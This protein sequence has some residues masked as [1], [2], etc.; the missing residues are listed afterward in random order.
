MLLTFLASPSARE[1]IASGSLPLPSPV[2]PTSVPDGFAAALSTE[3]VHP[4]IDPLEWSFEMRKRAALLTLGL[5]LTA[6]DAG[7]ELKDASAYNVL[8]DGCRPVFVD[9]GSFREGYSGHW[10]GYGQF[11]DHFINPL[12]VE[13]HAGVPATNL[14]I[15]IDGLTTNIAR[16]FFSATDLTKPGIW[17]WV[18]RRNLAERLGQRADTETGSR[19]GE[20]HLPLP[21][22]KGILQKATRL[23]EG[24]E[25]RASSQWA[26]YIE[27]TLPYSPEAKE[28]K[29]AIVDEFLTRCAPRTVLDVG[30]NTGEFA[31]MAAR[32]ATRVVATDNDGRAI[33]RLVVRG[34][35]APWGT[36]VTPA[37][38]D[39]AR[40]TPSYGW[41]GIERTGFL[42]RIG[43]VDLSLWLAVFH[44]LTLTSGIPLHEILELVKA[45]SRQAVIEFIDPGD[46][47]I[48]KMTA[49]RRWTTVAGR[50]EF[51]AALTSA[52]I[53][54]DRR[55]QVSPTRDLLLVTCG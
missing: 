55:E 33:D 8:F 20:A 9:L 39:I 2:E 30:T 12:L 13:A 10:P 43:R 44:H 40:P 42:Q 31:E 50:E 34:S 48:L 19:I 21:A 49:G 27:V 18:V 25:S 22:V 5:S 7:F 6:L 4:V 28:R 47:S 45:T 41:R 53:R 15:A 32:S 52:G 14:D 1:L 37:V 16:K 3:I 26:D 38:M 23:V 46:Q 36:R 29:R 17:S 24:L 51:D 11:G 54:V 35:S